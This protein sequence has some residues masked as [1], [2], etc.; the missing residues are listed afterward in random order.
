M[1]KVETLAEQHLPWEYYWLGEV[2]WKPD[3]SSGFV[4]VKTHYALKICVFFC[5]YVI[6]QF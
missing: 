1:I 2:T 6:S 4:G 5:M 3:L